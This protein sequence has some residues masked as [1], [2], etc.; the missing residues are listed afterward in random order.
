MQR[1]D[2]RLVLSPT[3]LTKHQEC[4]HLTRLDLAVADGALAAPVEGADEQL[5]LIFRLGLE[6]EAR[7]LAS[8]RA[9]G[10]S[11]VEIETRFDDRRRAEAETVAAMRA[12]ADVVYQATFFD[13]AVV[14]FA[15]FVVPPVL[16]STGGVA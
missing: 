5:E 4:R 3:D 8:L 16:A 11:I 9:Q 10:L 12:G 15:D 13:G 1:L 2:G 6:H 14:G 7:Y